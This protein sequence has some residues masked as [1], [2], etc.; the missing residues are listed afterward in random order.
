VEKPG[1]YIGKSEW[2]C[3]CVVYSAGNST[4]QKKGKNMNTENRE[5]ESN[6]HLRDSATQMMMRRSRDA[7]KL[8]YGTLGGLERFIGWHV[9]REFVTP[10]NDRHITEELM[11]VLIDGV[12][13]DK[14][15]GSLDSDPV[16]CDYVKLGDRVLVDP[17]QIL[18]V[19]GLESAQ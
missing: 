6:H 8:I 3:V 4:S 18:E 9:K 11:W 14:L 2:Q 19:M 5:P 16:W 1:I 15:T 10:P 17:E 12:D 13:G 7:G